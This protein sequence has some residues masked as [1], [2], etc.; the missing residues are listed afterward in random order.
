MYHE[1][2]PHQYLCGEEDGCYIADIP[3]LEAYSAFGETAAE[4]L[5]EVERAKAAWIEEQHDRLASLYL[6]HDTPGNLPGCLKV[7]SACDGS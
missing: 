3:D 2:L 4:T 7:Y 5:A 6:Q 1:R